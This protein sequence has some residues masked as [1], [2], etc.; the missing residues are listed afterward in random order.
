MFKC[1]LLVLG[2]SFVSLRAQILKPVIKPPQ[3]QPLSSLSSCSRYQC[4]DTTCLP[5]ICPSIYSANNPAI[6]PIVNLYHKFLS[7]L[8]SSIAITKDTCA[9]GSIFG[10]IET[11][12]QCSSSLSSGQ[13]LAVENTFDLESIPPKTNRKLTSLIPLSASIITQS[14]ISLSGSFWVQLVYYFQEKYY[15]MCYDTG[16]RVPVKKANDKNPDLTDYE[17]FVSEEYFDALKNSPIREA[18]VAGDLTTLLKCLPDTSDFKVV[19]CVSG[20]SLTHILPVLVE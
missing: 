10:P 17:T 7:S 3:S 20:S 13:N 9:V 15:Y 8:E 18:A 16:M 14:I 19:K 4:F 12:T 2:G 1:L 6:I 5:K 11:L